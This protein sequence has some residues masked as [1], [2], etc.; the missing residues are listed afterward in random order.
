[1]SRSTGSKLFSSR[2]RPFLKIIFTTLPLFDGESE[3]DILRI[4]HDMCDICLAAVLG[5][6]INERS[7]GFEDINVHN[8]G[9]NL[10]K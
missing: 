10:C 1:M 2:F 5:N 7:A 6:L 8:E 4:L 9:Q 3:V